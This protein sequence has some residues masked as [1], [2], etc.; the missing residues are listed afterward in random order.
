MMSRREAIKTTA[1]A[2]AA[3]AVGQVKSTSAQPAP[4]PAPAAGPFALP[5]LP[6]AYDALEPYIEAQTVTIHHDKHH[7]TYVA[8][9]NKAV[10]DHAELGKKSVDELVR[11]LASVPEAVRTAVRNHGG[12]VANHNF[13]WLSLKK[14]EGAA[15]KG[16]L[17][18]AIEKKFSSFAAFQDQWTKAATTLFGSGWAWLTVDGSKELRIEATPN[19]DS[20]L[21]AGRTPLLTIDVWEHAYYLKYQNRRAEHIAAFYN[22]IHWDM[23]T[24]RYLKAIA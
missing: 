14:N 24:E 8:N 1:L 15:P 3:A 19:Q 20:P 12:G 16:E 21:T 11:D 4:L 18:K 13:Y 7:A 17:L 23:V 10:A 5:P 22:L 6:Y 2:T 9:L